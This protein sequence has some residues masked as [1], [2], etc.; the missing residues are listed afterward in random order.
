M[1]WSGR[2]T[3]R[4]K[5]F[6]WRLFGRHRQ[7]NNHQYPH[8]AM[9]RVL[10]VLFIFVFETAWSLSSGGYENLTPI[11]L[12]VEFSSVVGNDAPQAKQ[13]GGKCRYMD[14]NNMIQTVNVNSEEF[15]QVKDASHV[16]PQTRVKG[17]CGDKCKC[18]QDGPGNPHIKCQSFQ[19]KCGLFGRPAQKNG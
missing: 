8:C 4:I 16:D 17:R 14:E 9:A 10:V 6:V 5:K 19:E 7:Y 2:Y 3:S 18:V 15:S 12:E 1:S 13:G 11:E